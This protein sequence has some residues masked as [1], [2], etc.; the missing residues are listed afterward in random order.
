MEKSGVITREN[1]TLLEEKQRKRLRDKQNENK[2]QEAMEVAEVVGLEEEIDSATDS[3]EEDME[4][5]GEIMEVEIDQVAVKV[6][7]AAMVIT[8]ELNT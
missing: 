6:V 2:D 4:M 1:S 5:I 8:D 7:E 3:M